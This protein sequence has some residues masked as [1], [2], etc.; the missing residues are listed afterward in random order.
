MATTILVLISVLFAL[1]GIGEISRATLGVGLVCLGC[2]LG[3]LARIAQAWQAAKRAD[4]F[5]ERLLK[6]LDWK[7]PTA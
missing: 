5:N 1:G 3:I 4:Q 2:Y 7:T 6:A